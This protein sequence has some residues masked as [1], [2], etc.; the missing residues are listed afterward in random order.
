[1]QEKY[2]EP[3]Y[4]KL[5]LKS[6]GMP[7]CCFLCRH[8]KNNPACDLFASVVPEEFAKKTEAC[9]HWQDSEGVPF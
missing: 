5:W 7:R 6:P 2:E 8:F 9:P 3:E 1:M 4:V